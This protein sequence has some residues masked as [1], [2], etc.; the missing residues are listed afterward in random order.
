MARQKQKWM[1]ERSDKARERREIV[2]DW[3]SNALVELIEERD[4]V[5]Q[6]GMEG[7][8]TKSIARLQE[9]NS[10]VS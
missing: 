4:H 7:Y 10:S 6:F 9:L 1:K 3:G 5:D 2:K 8:F